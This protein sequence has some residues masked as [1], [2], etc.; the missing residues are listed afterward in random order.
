[1]TVFLMQA[2]AC[3]VGMLIVAGGLL[4]VVHLLDKYK[5][6]RGSFGAGAPVAAYFVFAGDAYAP[7]GGMNDFR[8]Q[9]FSLE[10]A[11]ALAES[12]NSEWADIAVWDGTKLN[13]TVRARRSKYGGPF[14]WDANYGA[15]STRTGPP[16]S[17]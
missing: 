14:N 7:C 3:A 17:R 1:M 2:A 8:G 10:Q 6:S 12:I 16:V 5:W 11:K 4:A 15:A 13:P 9:A